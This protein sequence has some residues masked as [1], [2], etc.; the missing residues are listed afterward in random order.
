MKKLFLTVATLALLST[1]SFA[2]QNNDNANRM[3]ELRK[4]MHHSKM[5]MMQEMEMI[6]K[7]AAMFTAMERQMRIMEENM[8]NKK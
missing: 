1:S 5:M 6:K 7:Q 8:T 4:M 2:D 3:D